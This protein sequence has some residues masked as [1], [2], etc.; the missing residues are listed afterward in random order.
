MTT[1]LRSEK[2]VAIVIAIVLCHLL[3][4]AINTGITSLI[5]G[6]VARFVAAAATVIR[7]PFGIRIT[8]ASRRRIV[9]AQS[10]RRRAAFD[11]GC[12]V[13]INGFVNG[14]GAVLAQAL[15]GYV[16]S[17]ILS[18]VALALAAGRNNQLGG[19][20][21]PCALLRQRGGTLP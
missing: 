15:G 18:H 13:V 4:R 17:R 3:T 9:V 14:F 12:R 6:H 21:R 11:S 5:G 1:G 20:V 8:S 16:G 2:V 10:A 7:R 19:V